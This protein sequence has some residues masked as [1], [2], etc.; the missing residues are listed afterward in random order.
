MTTKNILTNE[1]GYGTYSTI[2]ASFTHNLNT[3]QLVINNY[4]GSYTINMTIYVNIIC[5]GQIISNW[6][7]DNL[8][9]AKET[10]NKIFN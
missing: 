9:D 2:V 3:K 6:K 4:I 7:F 5:K 10:Y 1:D 8:H